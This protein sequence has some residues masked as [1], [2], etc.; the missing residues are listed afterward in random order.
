MVGIKMTII[1]EFLPEQMSREEIM[2]RVSEKLTSDPI[3]PSKKGQFIG[4]MM[5]ELGSN[6]DGGIVKEVIDELVK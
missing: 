6:A 3:D 2:K 5:R 1:E 4:A